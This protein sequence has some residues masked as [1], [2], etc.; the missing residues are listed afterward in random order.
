VTG[1]RVVVIGAGPSGL[2]AALAA[3]RRGAE[4]TVLE[5]EAV[6]ASLRRWGAARFFTPLGMNLPPGARA[7]L[8]AG[9][10]GGSGAR[11]LPADEALLTGAE[12]VSAVLEPLAASPPLAGRVRLGHRVVAV[13]RAGMIRGDFAGHPVRGERPFRLLVETPEGERWLEADRVLDASGAM[14]APAALGAGGVPAPGERASAGRTIRDLGGIEAR[15]P[16]LGGRRILLVGHGHSAANALGVLE[17]LAAAA[18]GTAVTWA[19]RSANLRPCVDVPSDPLPERS[20]V[21]GRA[22][23]LAARPPAWLRVERRAAVERIVPAPGPLEVVL[24]GGR[25]VV[26]DAIVAL[27]GYRPDLTFLSELALEIAPATEGSARLARALASVT[28][29]LSVPRVAPADLASGEPGFHL[30]GAKS[31]GRARTFLLQTGYAQI[32]TLL[33]AAPE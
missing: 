22:N 9:A 28:D 24:T 7:A 6:G 15:R 19:V 31:Y 4:V 11:P 17:E 33:G 20:R 1:L 5:A 14:A 32:E 23:D 2:A 3:V 16:E 18:P 29:C 27:T 21:V 26:A 25:A 8:E 13:G 10:G 30:V 12:M